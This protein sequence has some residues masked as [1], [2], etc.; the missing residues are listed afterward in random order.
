[1]VYTSTE[2]NLMPFYQSVAKTTKLRVIVYNG[3]TDPSINSFMAQNWTSHLGFTPT[4][5]WRA[6]TLDSCRGM[7]GYVTRY[8]GERFDYLTIRGS[9]HMV[10]QFKPA[11]AYEFLRAWLKGEDYKPYVGS[12][13]KPPA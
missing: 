4:Q 8:E 5:P 9:G 3:D 1:M 7:G 10:P 13:K 6:W 2:P 12:C 11:A